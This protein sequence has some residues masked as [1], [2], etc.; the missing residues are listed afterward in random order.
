[1]FEDIFTA[2]GGIN[3]FIGENLFTLLLFIQLPMLLVW[4]ILTLIVITFI[5][6]RN[7]VFVN[8]IGVR[9]QITIIKP[10]SNFKLKAFNDLGA[11]CNQFGFSRF[12]LMSTDALMHRPNMTDVYP[13]GEVIVLMLGADKFLVGSRHIDY[14]NRKLIIDCGDITPSDAY[15]ADKVYMSNPNWIFDNIHI[16]SMLLTFW[17]FTSVINFFG[18]VI[19]AYPFFL[20]TLFW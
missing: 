11:V 17:I 8:P 2:M 15:Y 6:M 12:K 3:Q 4:G 19:V 20:K 16:V 9:W 7:Y 5:F 1:V 13:N 18:W 10:Y 14:T